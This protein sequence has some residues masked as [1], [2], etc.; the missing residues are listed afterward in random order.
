MSKKIFV[1]TILIVLTLACNFPVARLSKSTPAKASTPAPLV[2]K[3]QGQPGKPVN[4]LVLGSDWR[5]NAG[6]RTDV[7]LFVSINPRRGTVS[8]IS[9]PRDLW[10]SIP[11]EG[12]NR[13]N[14]TQELG[15]FNLTAQ[16][17]QNNFGIRPDYYIMTTF[18]GFT[19]MIDSLGGI[20]V[21][22]AVKLQD[23][24][25]LPQSSNGYC[26]AGPGIV[27]MDGKTALWYVR[28]RYTSSDFDRT[29]RTQ[30]VIQAAFVKLLSI[31]ALIKAPALVA[32]YRSST[33]TNLTLPALLPLTATALLINLPG[34]VQHYT[35]GPDLVTNYVVP[36][37]GAMVLL[38]HQAAIMELIHKA[39]NTP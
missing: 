6:F 38:P 19:S 15:G 20:D 21:N 22:A 5:P 11:G 36:G 28:S 33:E 16:T 14:T 35:I 18:T 10:V 29:R 12:M 9:F 24:C 27:H 26:T 17:F 2:S 30:E 31:N 1:L 37:S 25:D 39:V 34:H 32:A 13:I 23:R 3:P 7:M 8:L 4:I